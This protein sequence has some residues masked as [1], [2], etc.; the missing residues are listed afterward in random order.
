MVQA[1][2]LNGANF[3]NQL[4]KLLINNATKIGSIIATP[5][6]IQVFI[7]NN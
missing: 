2:S 5:L 4:I 6:V 7:V 3:N 1:K